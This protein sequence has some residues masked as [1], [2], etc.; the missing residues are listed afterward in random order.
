MSEWLNKESSLF[1]RDEKGELLAQ[2]VTLD[3]LEDKPK[4]AVIPMARGKLLRLKE[5]IEHG[6]N[7]HEQDIEVILQHC[8]QPRFTKEE[9][10]AL[11]PKFLSAINMAILAVSLD[12]T[13]EKLQEMSIKKAIEMNEDL[14]KKKSN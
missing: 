1:Q 3:L 9:A 2:E 10:Q 11:K 6:K 12:I 5:E 4:I 14:L 13:Q 7:S 8:I